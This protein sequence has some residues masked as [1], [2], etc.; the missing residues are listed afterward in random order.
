MSTVQFIH[1]YIG[2]PL[3][4]F[5]LSLFIKK[6]KEQVLSVISY[7]TAALQ[8]ILVLIYGISWLSHGSSPAQFKELSVYSSENYEFFIDFLVDKLTLV[9]ALL[10]ASLTFLITIYSRYYLHREEGYKRF[11]NTILFFNLGYTLI[12][13]SGNMETLFI[14]WEILGVSSFLLIAFY[15]ER[16]LPVKNALKVFSVYRIGDIGI[17]L[18]MWL[19][20]HLWHSNI[21][22]LEMNASVRLNAELAGTSAIGLTTAFL[23]YISAAAK[24]AQL[25]FSSWLPR[26]MEGPTPSSAIFYGSM[27]VHIGAFLLLRTMHF[28][29]NQLV[30]KVFLISAGLLTAL[31]TTAI[32]RVQSSI[33]SQIAYASIAQIGLIFVEIAF[34]LEN[35]ALIHILGNAFLRTYQLL[36]SPSIVSYKIREQLYQANPDQQ[37]KSRLW[38]QFQLKIYLL[39][40]KEWNLDALLYQLIWNPLKKIGRGWKILNFQYVFWVMAVVLLL[41][42]VLRVNEQ[43]LTADL[44]HK[45]PFFFAFWG[46]LI[47]VKALSERDSVRKSLTLIMF[48][49]VSISLA[50]SFNEHFDHAHHIWYLSGVVAAWALGYFI[51]TK[52]RKKEWVSLNNFYGH[53]YEYP[54][55]G[56]VF[57]LVCLSLA[58]FPITPSFVGED[59]IFS[60]I[61]LSQ[62]GLAFFTAFSLV[63]N[64]LATMRIYARVFLGPHI[65]TYHQIA[66]RSS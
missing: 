1:A 24:S 62:V 65:K 58:G 33:K 12:I 16:L 44:I 59:L 50:L 51:L 10:G 23:F 21:T 14:G 22:F 37:K 43:L 40:L 5:L 29:E 2:M 45:L 39:N 53:I 55:T 66:K 15:R 41:G 38:Q 64:G 20:H 19:L 31:I 11:F 46:F 42:L 6:S 56:F 60:H 32:S 61:H 26:A 25:P 48:N 36:I 54:K 27:S 28:W 4:G 49:H 17:I 30:F 34:G 18:A 57:L 35:L 9:F 63:I 47:A 7:T 3:F 52:L 8:L 13:F